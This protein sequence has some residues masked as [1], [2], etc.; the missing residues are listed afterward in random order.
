MIGIQGFQK[1]E[2]NLSWQGGI[3]RSDAKTKMCKCG[4]MIQ[5]RSKSCKSCWQRGVTKPHTVGENNYA[6]K[7]SKVGYEALHAWVY[8]K[9]G[10]AN[11]CEF[12]S[13]KKIRFHWANKSGE[14]KRDLDDWIS[15]C[16]SC[17]IN[18]DKKMGFWGISRQKY[19]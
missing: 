18:Y 5:R 13:I 1:G 15:L 7:G 17:H 2:L 10:K 6:W 8:R 14:Y 3:G 9:L 12:C 19:A 16:Q 11:Y 4:E